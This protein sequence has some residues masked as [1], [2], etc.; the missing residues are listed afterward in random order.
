MATQRSESHSSP[1]S[2]G[3]GFLLTLPE[4]IL[5]SKLG[6][7]HREPTVVVGRFN[8]QRPG[9]ISVMS[10]DISPLHCKI[11]L[12]NQG[13]SPA[14]VLRD[15]PDA[16]CGGTFVNG[17]LVPRSGRVLKYGDEI[18]FGRHGPRND[19]VFLYVE[20]LTDAVKPPPL[21]GF[22][23]KYWLGAPLG[24]GGY[25]KVYRAEHARSRKLFAVKVVTPDVVARRPRPNG[26]QIA[27]RE[28]ELMEK[29]RHPNIVQIVEHF[30][31]EGDDKLYIVMELVEKGDLYRYTRD[32]GGLSEIRMRD[33]VYQISRAMMFAHDRGVVHRDLK[34]SNILVAKE[35]PILVKIADF[36]DAN[37]C[38]DSARFTSIVGTPVYCAPEID[39]AGEKGYT[40]KVDSFS[41]G[42][43]AHFC[44]TLSEP[45]FTDKRRD[46]T[47]ITPPKLDLSHLRKIEISDAMASLVK[48]LLLWNPQ[49]RLTMERVCSHRLFAHPYVAAYDFPDDDPL[50]D[51]E[52]FRRPLTSKMDRLKEIAEE[53]DEG[54]SGS[55]HRDTEM[56]P[57]TP[58]REGKGKG[59]QLVPGGDMEMSPA[60]RVRR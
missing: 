34:P 27:G 59:R 12:H 50:S 41:L 26:R 54:A 48:S 10:N 39:T 18:R 30:L 42:A 40:F 24:Q 9:F 21:Q 28:V 33:V 8:Q 37:I 57:A 7:S 14:V 51:D 43:I 55:A 46:G 3:G 23:K 15:E 20:S 56:K 29:L 1:L 52:K 45:V 13:E 49:Q 16:S 6:L 19:N 53:E 38:G 47:P 31:C 17:Y 25:A 11:S 44:L 35:Y 58:L 22:F 4:R 60:K 2:N 32:S 5:H 36:G